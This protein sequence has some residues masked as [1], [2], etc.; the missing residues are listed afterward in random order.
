MQKEDCSYL[1]A[2]SK[3][4]KAAVSVIVAVDNVYKGEMAGR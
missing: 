2:Y 3:N 4:K 1:T